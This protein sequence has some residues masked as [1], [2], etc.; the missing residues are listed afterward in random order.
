MRCVATTFHQL[1]QETRAAWQLQHLQTLQ[2]QGQP[3]VNRNSTITTD[4]EP[5][6]LFILLIFCSMYRLVECTP[7][8]ITYFLKESPKRTE[9]MEWVWW[10][11]ERY[12]LVKRIA[13]ILNRT[14]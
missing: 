7:F 10:N 3:A 4:R 8:S 12:R 9:T 5:I 14:C 2:T 13:L 1:E 6:G 11:S